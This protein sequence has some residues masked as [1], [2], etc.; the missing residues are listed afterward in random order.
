MGARISRK[1]NLPTIKACDG[2]GDPVNQVRTL[3]IALLLQLV[4]ETIKCQA[5]P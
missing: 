4:I 2:M 5:F 3:M 1:F